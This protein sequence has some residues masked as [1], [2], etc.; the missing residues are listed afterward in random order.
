MHTVIVLF[1]EQGSL[2]L[3][4]EH[5][6]HANKAYD[7]VWFAK[8]RSGNRDGVLGDEVAQVRDDYGTSA[9]IEGAEV[10]A[11]V[12][13]DLAQHLRGAAIHSLMQQ[14]ANAEL[15]KKMASD[16]MLRLLTPNGP[17]GGAAFHG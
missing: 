5:L 12:I 17:L 2:Q 7:A 4:F 9:V 8:D 10:R 3:L 11:V 14:R 1:K 6:D 13:Q 15:Q 16:P